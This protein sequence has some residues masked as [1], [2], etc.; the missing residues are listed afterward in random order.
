MKSSGDSPESRGRGWVFALLAGL[1]V[2]FFLPLLAGWE[3]FFVDDIG[4]IF[5]PQ[6]TFLSRALSGGVIPW[7]NPHQAAGASFF[8][9]HLF[10]SALS[11]YNW[12]FLI[13]GALDPARDFLWLIKLPLALSFLLSAVFSYLFARRGL[14]IG[15]EGSFLFSLAYTLSPAMTYFALCPPEVYI[16]AWLPLFC[17][18]LLRFAETGRPGWLIGG[19]AAFAFISPAGDL[20]VLFHVLL[21]TALFGAGVLGLYLC[22]KDWKRGLRLVYGGLIIFGLGALLAGP[23]WANMLDGLMILAAETGEVVEEL[24]GLAQSLPP[25]YLLTLFVPDYFGEITSHH[26]W[27]AAHLMRIS[28]NDVNILGGLALSFLVFAGFLS[29][30]GKDRKPGRGF[31]FREYRWVFLGIFLFGVLVILGRY[32][33][34]Y[35]IFRRLIPVLQ[36]PYPTRFRS[37]QCFALAGLLGVS[38]EL[39]RRSPPPRKVRP[40][41]IYLIFVLVFAG[42]ALLHPFS[43]VRGDTF[44]P[45]FRQ[46]TA[47]GDWS[48]FLTG[49]VLYLVLAGVLVLVAAAFRGGKYFLRLLVLLVTAEVM[50]FSYRAF[51]H[52]RVLNHRYQ[53][54]TVD[55]YTGPGESPVYR[56]VIGWRPEGKGEAGFYRRLFH[57]SRFDN[58][59]WRD[60]SLSMLGFDI[61]PLDP[62]FSGIVEEL[63]EGFPYE[64]RRP[65]WISRFWLNMSGRYFLSDRPVDLPGLSFR[66]RRNGDYSY[67]A[68]QALPRFFFL[69]RVVGCSEAEARAELV[70]GDLRRGVFVEDGEQLA[71]SSEQLPGGGDS[72]VLTA[73]CLPLTAYRSF[74]PGGEDEYLSHFEGLQGAN[75]ITGID[76]SNPNR[77]V[78]DLQVETP[79]MLVVTDAWHPDWRATRDGRPAEVFR[80]NYLQRGIW[81]PAGEYRVIMSFRPSSLV[82]GL[83]ATAV[84]ILILGGMVYWPSRSRRRRETKQA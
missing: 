24:S 34:A 39:L 44:A 21:I 30:A 49:P 83:A 19:A 12:A 72:G 54:F 78:L 80:V 62:R 15:P 29:P 61:K 47:L 71:V 2:L 13:L 7:W 82:P 70:E 33:P 43:N 4:F 42:L 51:Y 8:Y 27:G 45:G 37:I 46:L 55:R 79:A 40:A 6:Q 23:Y 65:D 20:P 14:R 28:I 48:W 63:T 73:D 75:R 5:Y 32:T 16:Q 25:V 77:I 53:E 35:G 56:K 64:L 67:E 41:L 66:G 58:L 52:N 3:K 68:P 31:S 57:R 59:S 76:L 18:F 1:I 69:D 38:A 26:T 11:P 22:R 17:L 36:M 81:C 60:G 84:G 10:Q 50:F 74:T 9:G